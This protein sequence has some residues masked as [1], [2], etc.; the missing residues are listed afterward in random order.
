MTTL[1]GEKFVS[2]MIGTLCDALES[3]YGIL[4]PR[5]YR[6][7]RPRKGLYPCCVSSIMCIYVAAAARGR[8]EVAELAAAKKCEKYAEISTAHTFLPIA[9][10]TLGPMNESAYQFFDDLG[11]RFGDIS[12]DSRET[13]FISQRLSVTIQRFNAA[14]Y[15]E[16]FVLHDD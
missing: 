6:I 15:R 11:R 10:E 2:G 14:L 8:G 16:T 5:L 1:V 7:F 9:V 4:I 13:S 3:E 12:G